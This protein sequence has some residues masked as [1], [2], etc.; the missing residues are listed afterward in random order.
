[1]P[2]VLKEHKINKKDILILQENLIVRGWNHITFSALTLW[3]QQ[4]AIL[5]LVVKPV[6][7]TL[8]SV[9]TAD[10]AVP[11]VYLPPHTDQP[12]PQTPQL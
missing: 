7:P 9:E 11:A 3:A 4:K 12:R 1:M 8:L 5:P 6:S 2:V 10:A